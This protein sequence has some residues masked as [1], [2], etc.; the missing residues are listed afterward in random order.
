MKSLSSITRFS[1]C[2]KSDATI[3]EE[4]EIIAADLTAIG[5]RRS[6]V[7]PAD[8]DR[9]LSFTTR[10]A[11]AQDRMVAT[12]TAAAPMVLDSNSVA[13]AA[14]PPIVALQKA[15]RTIGRVPIARVPMTHHNA[16]ASTTSRKTQRVSSSSSRARLRQL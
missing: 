15:G 1:G 14:R 6:A 12:T 4:Q 2:T 3:S 8:T 5:D 11:E 16:P 13:P 9:A 10:D 7:L